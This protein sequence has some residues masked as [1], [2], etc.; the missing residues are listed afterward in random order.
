[1]ARPARDQN[2]NHSPC[3]HLMRVAS[4]A[5]PAAPTRW[6]DG[7]RA[8]PAAPICGCAA[9]L[10]LGPNRRAQ[11]WRLEPQY[12][13]AAWQ[14]G[15][16]RATGHVHARHSSIFAVA[17][18]LFG[19]GR[20]SAD[21]VQGQLESHRQD[22]LAARSMH[23]STKLKQL[24]RK[25]DKRA[26]WDYFAHLCDGPDVNEYHCSIMLSVCRRAEDVD[27]VLALSS[28]GRVKTNQAVSTCAQILDFACC[29]LL[30]GWWASNMWASQSVARCICE[31]W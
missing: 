9:V 14:R 23:A 31:N 10:R 2:R 28:Q 12:T 5:R 18:E 16:L 8:R 21:A 3:V 4:R 20:G 17:R 7:G 29:S 13:S 30:C 25:P 19:L 27:R 22:I 1:M 24:L 15:L 26:A 11:A 6:V